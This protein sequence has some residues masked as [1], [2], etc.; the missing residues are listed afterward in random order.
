MWEEERGKRSGN[1][2][3]SVGCKIDTT[4]CHKPF[5]LDADVREWSQKL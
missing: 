2:V 1:G 3:K 5:S 4:K